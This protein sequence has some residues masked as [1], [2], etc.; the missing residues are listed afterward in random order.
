MSAEQAQRPGDARGT[1]TLFRGACG[2][3]KEPGAQGAMAQAVE[4]ELAAVN[5]LQSGPVGGVFTLPSRP[6]V[7]PVQRTTDLPM[8]G[9]RAVQQPI[10]GG[11]VSGSAAVGP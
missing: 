9:M 11:G 10:Q 5:R 4:G 8:V 3:G 6:V 7:L 1:P 2:C